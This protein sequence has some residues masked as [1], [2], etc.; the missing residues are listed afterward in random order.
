MNSARNCQ[1]FRCGTDRIQ[2]GKRVEYFRDPKHVILIPYQNILNNF[3]ITSKAN[4]QAANSEIW[5]S[6]K[7]T[8]SIECGWFSLYF[9]NGRTMLVTRGSIPRFAPKIVCRWKNAT[10]NLW[11]AAVKLQ[12][13][14]DIISKF[15]LLNLSKWLCAWEVNNFGRLAWESRDDSHEFLQL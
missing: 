7:K 1:H 15:A 9:N 12:V 3:A 10:R 2:C 6:E 5:P 13:Y 4:D 11:L 8:E 14:L